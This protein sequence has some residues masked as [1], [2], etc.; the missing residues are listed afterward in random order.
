MQQLY[1]HFA[2]HCNDKGLRP[3]TALLLS[4]MLDQKLVPDTIMRQ[5]V[6]LHTF[7][8]LQSAPDAPSKTAL[9]R[10]LAGMFELHENTVWNLLKDHG[11][12][13]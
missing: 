3:N 12:K 13:W 7:R 8:K 4:Y 1:I 10:K 9:V 5:Y 11:G 6:V 2:D